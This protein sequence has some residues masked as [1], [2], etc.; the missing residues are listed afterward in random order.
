[1][2]GTLRSL[3]P[4]V[5]SP[6]DDWELSQIRAIW[7]VGEDFLVTVLVPEERR[8]FPNLPVVV[9]PALMEGLADII[10]RKPFAVRANEVAE[11]GSFTELAHLRGRDGG[12]VGDGH[13]A[14]ENDGLHVEQHFECKLSRDK[15]KMLGSWEQ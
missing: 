8:V 7:D 15:E 3:T 13:E 5:H 2:T 14:V 11:L 10:L 1:M 9:S 6:F 4:C 12:G